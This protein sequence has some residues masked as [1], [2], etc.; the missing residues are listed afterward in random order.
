MLKERILNSAVVLGNTDA[1]TEVLYGCGSISTATQTTQGGHTGIIPTGYIV[2]FNQTAQLSLG[3]NGVVDAETGKFY[4]T[5][6]GG[7]GDIFDHP[8]VQ[9]TMVFVFQRT[10]GM[11]NAFKRV[12]NRMSKIVHGVNAPFC[13]LTVMLDISDAVDN[14][15]AHIE[16]AGS[17]VYLCAESVAS[18]GELA[19]FHALKKV[20]AFFNGTVTPGTDGRFAY[21]TAVCL[22]FLGSELADI[23]QPFF[24][25][26]NSVFI[27]FGEIVGAIE[28]T[29]IPVETE[30]VDI[31]LNGIH[32]FGIFLCGV[33][34]IHTEVADT[35]VFFGCAKVYAKS[36]AVTD[37]KVAVGFGRKTGMHLHTFTAST[38]C[39]ILF[40]KCVY[41]V[42]WRFVDNDFVCHV[43][44]Y[45]LIS[46]HLFMH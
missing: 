31:F 12:L 40:D 15:V 25:Q 22:E 32:V 36:F 42:L 1:F 45:S 34:I 10:Q 11:G 14:G 38:R 24:Y 16:I 44:I 8:V 4:L 6:S 33:G 7:N 41:K 20:Q 9:G 28:E 23:G 2:F 37:V 19:V 18:F 26:L 3:H 30:P 27:C 29:V 13:A 39:Q 21:I 35:A 17:K 5:G 43:Y 46:D